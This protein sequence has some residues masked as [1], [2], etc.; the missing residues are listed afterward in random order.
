V[1]GQY[2]LL[3]RTHPYGVV[4]DK[5]FELT[6]TLGL[7]ADCVMVSTR[8]NASEQVETNGTDAALMTS[9]QSL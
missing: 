5:L 6:T 7:A 2:E 8:S 3:A 1:E 9:T 4:N